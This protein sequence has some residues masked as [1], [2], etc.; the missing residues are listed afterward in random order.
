MRCIW[1]KVCQ[2][3]GCGDTQARP[4]AI[5]LESHPPV[6]LPPAGAGE[7]EREERRDETPL[8]MGIG[9]G[10]VD[11]FAGSGYQTQPVQTQR[12]TGNG[13]GKQEPQQALQH[14]Q[15]RDI[16]NDR[17]TRDIAHREAREAART[18]DMD[19]GVA[20]A[21]DDLKRRDEGKIHTPSDCLH[22][23]AEKMRA[24]RKAEAAERAA[25]KTS[26]Q[27]AEQA[28]TRKPTAKVYQSVTLNDTVGESS[29]LPLHL[30]DGH[31]ERID[32]AIAGVQ[33]LEQVTDF[34]K[35]MSMNKEI[36]ESNLLPSR[37]TDGTCE[38][39]DSVDAGMYPHKQAAEFFDNLSA[40]GQV[41]ESVRVSL[42]SILGS[43]SEETLLMTRLASV[44]SQFPSGSMFESPQSENVL[45]PGPISHQVLSDTLRISRAEDVSMVELVAANNQ[46]LDLLNFD[47][48]GKDT[49]PRPISGPID[50]STQPPSEL[51]FGNPSRIDTPPDSK[52]LRWPESFFGPKEDVTSVNSS[53]PISESSQVP[54]EP[55]NPGDM[56]KPIDQLPSDSILGSQRRGYF[57]PL[58]SVDLERKTKMREPADKSNENIPAIRLRGGSS[59]LPITSLFKGLRNGEGS[60]TKS[61]D[62]QESQTSQN[63]GIVSL[64]QTA[65]LVDTVECDPLFW[66]QLNVLAYDIRHYKVTAESQRRINGD[67]QY[68]IEPRRRVFDRLLNMRQNI[69]SHVNLPSSQET[70]KLDAIILNYIGQFDRIR[71]G[72]IAKVEGRVRNPYILKER[73]LSY[74]APVLEEAIGIFDGGIQLEKRVWFLEMLDEHRFQPPREELEDWAREMAGCHGTATK[75]DLS[76]LERREAGKDREMGPLSYWIRK[77]RS[78]ADPS[79]PC[80][81]EQ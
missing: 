24:R 36:G 34:I 1:F 23:M 80:K 22:A 17:L 32:S 48:L 21:D 38:T 11:G 64:T 69:P 6:M 75:G 74:L 67:F 50:E 18:G 25:Q 54:S 63:N 45:I 9:R 55:I 53:L 52:D 57:G 47:S 5:P 60:S 62:A 31:H 70:L 27:A 4:A 65:T 61:A 19:F 72:E 12:P 40:T 71:E 30:E 37:P 81:E 51:T 28:A 16:F 3:L 33:P 66:Y 13:S 78:S 29:Q 42:E 35:Y 26:Q 20:L 68:F 43:L 49:V 8:E 73:W 56:L 44:G 77:Y 59:Q 79:S 39:P 10:P 2:L 76:K 7:E 14:S 58:D 41:R 46:L 15:L